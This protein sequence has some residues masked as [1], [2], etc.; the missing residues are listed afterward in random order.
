MSLPLNECT[1]ALAQAAVRCLAEPSA[2]VVPPHVFINILRSLA[3][4]RVKDEE[5]LDLIAAIAYEQRHSVV[6]TPA[7]FGRLIWAVRTLAEPQEGEGDEIE[8]DSAAGRVLV[9]AR[10]VLETYVDRRLG[11]PAAADG[12][13][14]GSMPS[15]AVVLSLFSN[16]VHTH[17]MNLSAERERDACVI[18]VCAFASFSLKA[19]CCRTQGPWG[20]TCGSSTGCGR[21]WWRPQTTSRDSTG[22]R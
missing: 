5:L 7:A 1:A 18:N 20:V 21:L 16:L 3:E 17:L 6:E 14:C 19:G 9:Y 2:D 11:A 12:A 22:R 8:A 10:E 13:A 15:A 4:L